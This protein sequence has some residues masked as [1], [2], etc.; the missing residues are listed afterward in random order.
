M[1][2]TDVQKDQIGHFAIVTN[3]RERCKLYGLKNSMQC[4]KCQVFLC[5][6]KNNNCFYTFHNKFVCSLISYAISYKIK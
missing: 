2:P 6:N 4:T 1:P 3:L 5:L